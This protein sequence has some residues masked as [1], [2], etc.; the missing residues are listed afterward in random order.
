[1]VHRR[2]QSAT[3]LS[4]RELH[5]GDGVAATS[6]G[7]TSGG[8]TLEELRPLWESLLAATGQEAS[9]TVKANMLGTVG[10]V[11]CTDIQADDSDLMDN[12]GVGLIV[13]VLGSGHISKY[14]YPMH[15]SVVDFPPLV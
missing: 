10:F 2:Y 6:Q 12:L 7:A 13:N 3:R 9:A 4:I 5:Q 1:M 14:K 15:T 8:V 11:L